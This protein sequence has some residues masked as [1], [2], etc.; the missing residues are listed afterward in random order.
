MSNFNEFVEFI[1]EHEG[2]YVNHPKDPGGE[3]KYGI[4][5]KFYPELDIKN[6]TVD[7]AKE[8]YFNDYWKKNKC[9]QMHPAVALLVFD[10]TVNQGFVAAGKILQRSLRI[11]DDGIIGP[12][13][14]S[15][16]NN[17]NPMI[18]IKE[19]TS[20]RALYYAHTRNVETFGL[21][22]YRRLVAAYT[23]SLKT[24]IES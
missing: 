19:F 14:L 22:W 16:V 9:D 23:L 15:K 11:T 8:I 7:Q 10:S 2:G 5:K 1:L 24:I 3:T 21:G 20:Q 4:A 17:T 13:T 6:L 12:Q 18:V